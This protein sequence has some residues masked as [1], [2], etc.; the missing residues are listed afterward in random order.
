VNYRVTFTFG[1]DDH[2]AANW[3]VSRL[4]ARLDRAG[5]L[6]HGAKFEQVEERF[7]PVTGT[8]APDLEAEAVPVGDG[9]Y[10]S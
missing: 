4:A 1:A 3:I 2:D 9:T 7:E 6:V 8:G 5:V 10:R